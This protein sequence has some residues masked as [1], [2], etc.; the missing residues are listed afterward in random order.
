MERIVIIGG[1]VGGTL[2]A[3]LLANADKVPAVMHQRCGR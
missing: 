1:G 2:T 3:N